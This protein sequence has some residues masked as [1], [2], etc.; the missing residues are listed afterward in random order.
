[1]KKTSWIILT[2]VGALI[3]VGSV[4]SASLAYSKNQYPIGPAQIGE[5][6]AGRE[7][8]ES[9][10]RGMRATAAA[11]GA[12]YGVLLLTIVLG[13]Y[14]RGEVWAWWAVLSAG[15]V[16]VAIVLLRI[17]LLGTQLGVGPAAIQVGLLVVG[18]LFDVRRLK[19]PAR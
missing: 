15:I 7:A 4:A 3:L 10:L 13:P 5:V 1:M 9:A 18:L 17:P 14:R 11:Y 6:A 16:L 8:V 12:A 2:I 19:S